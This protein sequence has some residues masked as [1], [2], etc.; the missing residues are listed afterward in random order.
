MV[1]PY[2]IKRRGAEALTLMCVTMIYPA[3]GW[4][5][6]KDVK[7]KEVFTVATAVE[8]T[9]LNQYPWATEIIFDRGS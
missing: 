3:T 6:M 1:D 8:Q 7:N 2:T 5:E 9:W 4:F